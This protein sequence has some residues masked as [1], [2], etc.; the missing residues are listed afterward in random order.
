[1][2]ER[3]VA[4]S[5]EAF[6]RLV[7]RHERRVYTLAMRILHRHEDAEEVVQDTFVSVIGHL[8]GFRWQS[9][10]GTWL[11]SIATN[12]ALKRLAKRRRQPLP[13]DAH[14]GTEFDDGP[15]SHPEFIA[16]WSGDPERLAEDHEVRELLDDALRQLDEKYRL[17]FLLRDVEGLSTEETAA[18]L[19]ISISNAKV[20]LLR[21]RLMLRERLTR[22]LGDPAT[23]IIPAHDHG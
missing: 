23:R 22:T 20:R 15:F 18:A 2:V 12:H 4:G 8:K 21:A 6:D 13:L 16:D 11:T 5:F 7:S 1:M 3:A 17:V 14:A 10:F 9:R 19:G